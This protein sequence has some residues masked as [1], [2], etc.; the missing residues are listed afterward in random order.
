VACRPS[1][2]YFFGRRADPGVGV[3]EEQ[4]VLALHAEDQHLGVVRLVAE[5]VAAED[6]VQ[7]EQGEATVGTCLPAGQ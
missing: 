1:A 5:D 2:S 3:V 7:Q 6:W 4:Q